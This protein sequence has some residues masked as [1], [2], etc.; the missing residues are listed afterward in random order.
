MYDKY[1][2]VCESKAT[3]WI[4]V[5]VIYSKLALIECI[6]PNGIHQC[7]CQKCQRDGDLSSRETNGPLNW[8]NCK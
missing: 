7:P 1:C 8:Q 4:H 5:V 2:H 6:N 3:K